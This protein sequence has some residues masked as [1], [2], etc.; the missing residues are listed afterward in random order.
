MNKGKTISAPN[1]H[2]ERFSYGYSSNSSNN[3]P[4]RAPGRML[5]V[6]VRFLV[7]G[8]AEGAQICEI[9]SGDPCRNGLR[10]IWGR[11]VPDRRHAANGRRIRGVD[12]GRSENP[13]PSQQ[14][15]TS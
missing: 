7:A 14:D 8:K 13:D 3:T 1:G 10:V 9:V 11:G 12:H 4:G 5:A 6:M 15:H 2:L